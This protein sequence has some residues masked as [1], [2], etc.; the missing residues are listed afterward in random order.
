MILS[1]LLV[2]CV[3]VFLL[4][5]VFLGVVGVFVWF[6]L[7]KAKGLSFFNGVYRFLSVSM[8]LFQGPLV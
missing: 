2:Q 7:G 4:L 3:S 5:E 8:I 1:F 6:W